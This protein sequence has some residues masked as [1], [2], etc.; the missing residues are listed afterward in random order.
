M[1][2]KFSISIAA[3]IMLLFTTVAISQIKI[4]EGFET[5]DSNNLPTGWSKCYG[6]TFPVNYDPYSNW[7][8]RDSGLWMPGLSTALTKA[9]SGIKSCGVSWWTGVDTNNAYHISDAWLV[10]KKIEN[11]Q[12][13]DVLKFWACGGTPTWVDSMQVWVNFIDSLPSNFTNKISSIVWVGATYG[14]FTLYTYSLAGYAGLPIYIGFRYNTDCINQG[15]A[16]YLDD[17]FVGNPNSISQI[18][19][20]IPTKYAL[21]Q[22]Y[23]NP[24][25]PVTTIKFDLPKSSHVRMTIYNTLGQVVSEILNETKAPGYYEVKFDASKL[26]SGPYFYRIEAGNF[27]ETKK[28]MVIK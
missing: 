9:H 4:Q 7:T 19:T 1:R 8:V 15:F 10:T 21:S 22:N 23:P 27:V 2:S 3:M 12:T 16:V 18:G 6:S 20:G 26:S 25:N 13:T 14:N 11:I 28:M 24:F 17:V 5:S